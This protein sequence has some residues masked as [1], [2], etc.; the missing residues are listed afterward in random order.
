MKDFQCYQLSLKGVRAVR[1]LLERIQKHDADLARQLRRCLA[2]VPLNIAE[3]SESRGKN[4][5]SRY[6]TAMGSAREVVACLQTAEA[7]GYLR[8]QD[9]PVAVDLF[10]HT[11]AILFK[12]SR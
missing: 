11:V 5:L 3:G 12:L 2:S 1:P 8:E 9:L 4:R 10:D 6:A 7:L